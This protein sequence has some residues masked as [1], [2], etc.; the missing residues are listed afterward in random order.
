[1]CYL[2]N[3][4]DFFLPY[5]LWDKKYSLKGPSIIMPPFLKALCGRT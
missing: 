3:L 2:L 4:F 1:M 5:G